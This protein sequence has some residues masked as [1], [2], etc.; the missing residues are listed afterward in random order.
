MAWKSTLVNPVFACIDNAL[1]PLAVI[2]IPLDHTGT[3]RPGT[4]FA[5][6]KIREAACNLEI[7]SLMANLDLEEIGFRDYGDILLQPGE[8]RKAVE[9]IELVT[10]NLFEEHREF[11]IILGGEQPTNISSHTCSRKQNRHTY[12]IRRALRHEKRVYRVSIK[13]CNISTETNRRKRH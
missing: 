3:Y 12:S 9:R 11:T 8:P 13:P 1:S 7:Y 4:R 2:G 10:R 5:P 6:Q